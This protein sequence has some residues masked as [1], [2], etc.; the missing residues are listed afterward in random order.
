MIL[1]AKCG[2]SIY[3]VIEF[4]ERLKFLR[5]E[6][7]L[8]QKQLSE[9]TGVAQSAIA[10]WENGKRLPTLPSLIILAKFFDV[11]IDYLAGLVEL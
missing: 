10:F 8:T 5:E 6:K 9:A 1:Y 4:K 7:G 2:N 11:S 3:M